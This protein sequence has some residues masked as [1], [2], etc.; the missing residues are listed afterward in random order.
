MQRE[1]LRFD[2]NLHADNAI[3]VRSYSRGF[4]FPSER[5]RVQKEIMWDIERWR[6]EMMM[7]DA[8]LRAR[9][10]ETAEDYV[11]V[12]G[13]HGETP[14]PWVLSSVSTFQVR[15]T[16]P[17]PGLSLDHSIEALVEG[18]PM[19]KLTKRAY[20]L[21]PHPDCALTTGVY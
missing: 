1:G 12:F 17:V 15:Y 11:Q 16:P 21:L 20:N 13:P 18:S 5:R 10:T 7:S 14:L 9:T 6:R 19:S 2:A 3:G 8:T 4:L